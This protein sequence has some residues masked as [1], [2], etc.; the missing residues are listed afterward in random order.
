MLTVED[1]ANQALSLVVEAP[2]SSLDENNKAAR[3]LSLHFETTRM[4]E[5]KKHAWAFSIFRV[6]IDAADE[7][8]TGTTYGYGYAA[9]EDAL[10]ILPLTDTGEA[11]GSSIPWKMEG[12]LILSSWSG[13][14]LV[15]YIANLTDPNDWD[16]LLRGGDGGSSGGQDRHASDGQER[17]SEGGTGRLP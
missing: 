6:E 15:R 5:L 9:P 7:V 8:P 16:P 17:A 4:A 1:V 11:H 12:N 2:I 14:R 13:P 3:L 10:R